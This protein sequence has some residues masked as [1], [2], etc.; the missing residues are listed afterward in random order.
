MSQADQFP[1]HQNFEFHLTDK[2]FM[3]GIIECYGRDSYGQLSQ[4]LLR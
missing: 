3:R 4:L 2:K 1:Y